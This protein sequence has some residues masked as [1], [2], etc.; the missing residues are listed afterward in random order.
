MKSKRNILL[1][2]GAGFI[3]F[4]TAAALLKRGDRVVIADNFNDYYDV[5]LKKARIAQ[6]GKIKR[7]KVYKTELSGVKSVERIFKKHRFTN[8]CHLAAQP[9]VRYSLKDP[10]RYEYYN[11]IATMNMLE[12]ARKYSVKKFVFASSSSVYGNNRKVPFS[13]K[14]NVDYPVSFYAATKKANEL[15][16][17]VYSSL[18][19]INITC[20]RFFTVYGPWGRPDMA[21]FKF[22]KAILNN[23]PIDVY[24]RGKMK[25]DFTYVSDIVKGI[26]KAIDRPMKYEVIN[27]GNNRPVKLTRLISVIEK[28]LGVKARKRMLGMQPGDVKKTYAGISKAKKLLGFSPSTK[29]EEGVSRFVKWYKGYYGIK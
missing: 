14:D 26:L 2:G 1:T 8:I 7:L 29:I 17:H 19:G 13:E 28:E 3:G 9:G 16:G 27:L 22:V 25:R 5:K 15:Y 12:M 6:L 20:L 21:M 18:Y 23:K 24:N 11:N 10:L 4:H